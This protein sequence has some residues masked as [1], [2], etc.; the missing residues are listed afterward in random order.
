M[1]S[2]IVKK[3]FVNIS[4]RK[5]ACSALVLLVPLFA[6][7]ATTP[8][9]PVVNSVTVDYSSNVVTVNGSG[10]LPAT[11]AP[12]VSFNTTN[13]MLVSDTD[14]QI[15]AYLPGG[16]AAGTFNLAVTNSVNNTFTFDVT[17][18]AVGPQGPAGPT[19]AQGAQGAQGASGPSGPA[20]P[21]GPQGQ[22]GILSSTGFSLTMVTLPLNEV[23][24]VAA[25]RLPNA[26]TYVIGG[27]L[28]LFNFDLKTQVEVACGLQDSSGDKPGLP[29]SDVR[30][31]GPQ[32]SITIPLSGFYVATEATE[33]QLTCLLNGGNAI[34][35]VEQGG[36]L[37]AIQVPPFQIVQRF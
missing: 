12:T 11:T 32:S 22:S 16:I 29:Y 35:R 27:Q 34:V 14:T 1:H 5:A 2:T 20:G 6:S 26:G 23:A 25:L 28:Q 30:F 17:Y 7:A 31:L 19:G 37:F 36:A 15:V 24:N 13:L 8:N 33:L 9:V 21:T 18:G 3:S 10:F 4:M